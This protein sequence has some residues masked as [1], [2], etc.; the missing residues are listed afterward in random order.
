[1][2]SPSPI[3]A[4][5]STPDTTEIEAIARDYIDGWYAGDVARM[6]RALHS[7]LVKRM[8]EG[9]G[10]GGTGELRMISKARMLELT[11]QGGGDMPDAEN[12]VVIDDISSTI[13]S[14]R[15]LSPEYVDYLHLVKTAAGWK[16][17]NV[18]FH[19]RA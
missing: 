6:D 8:L 18:L 1:M 15:V 10:D 5:Q 11:A 14:A 12:E 16:I 2:S 13:A 19:N 3:P 7:E 17:A 4:P 9:E